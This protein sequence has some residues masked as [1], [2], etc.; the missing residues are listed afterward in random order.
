MP[1][2]SS[3]TRGTSPSHLAVGDGAQKL[4]GA[5]FYLVLAMMSWA[6]RSPARREFAPRGCHCGTEE[7]H[8]STRDRAT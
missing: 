7:L 1:V 8:G 4:A 5:L 6:L 3:T 2:S